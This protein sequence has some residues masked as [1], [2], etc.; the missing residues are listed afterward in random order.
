[1]RDP[2]QATSADAA[3]PALQEAKDILNNEEDEQTTFE[4]KSKR[5][6][7]NVFSESSTSSNASAQFNSLKH[8]QAAPLEVEQ[9]LRDS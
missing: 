6:S 4:A 9:Q 5:N 8:Q 3:Q 1:M 2:G 7:K